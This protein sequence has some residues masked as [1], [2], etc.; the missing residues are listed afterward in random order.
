MNSFVNETD[1]RSVISNRNFLCNVILII[2]LKKIY[3]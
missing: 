2:L 1:H 3:K